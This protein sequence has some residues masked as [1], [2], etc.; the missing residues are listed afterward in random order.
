[1]V[2]KAEKSRAI[3]KQMTKGDSVS[4]GPPWSR[5]PRQDEVCKRFTGGDTHEGKR[6]QTLRRWRQLSDSP[7]VL[8]LRRRQGR[9]EHWVMS[10]LLYSA[11]LGARLIQDF[12]QSPVSFRHWPTSAPLLC[13]LWVSLGFIHERGSGLRGTTVGA[14]LLCLLQ[15][16]IWVVHF[17]CDLRI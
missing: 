16:D 14:G 8:P 1:M 9:Q 3:P 11:P 4:W 13:W 17:H 7:E 12:S 15:Q 6:R 10:V 5:H 2:G